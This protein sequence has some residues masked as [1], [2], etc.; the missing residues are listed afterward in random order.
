ML[1]QKIS[2]N[3][4]P[5]KMETFQPKYEEKYNPDNLRSRLRSEAT[6]Q[7]EDSDEYF[8]IVIKLTNEVGILEDLFEVDKA[9]HIEL[10]HL[11]SNI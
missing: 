8:D 10:L 11:K 9:M 2:K 1:I 4:N 3:Q 7:I 6:L 5:I